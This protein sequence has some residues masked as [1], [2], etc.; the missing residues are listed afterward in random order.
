MEFIAEM[1]STFD[2]Y[3]LLP[4]EDKV[5]QSARQ[6][7]HLSIQMEV[8][9]NYWIHFVVLERSFDSYRVLGPS[10]EDLRLVFPYG[11]IVDLFKCD[12][13][14]KTVTDYPLE[15]IRKYVLV[16]LGDCSGIELR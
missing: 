16:T 2:G 12:Y 3:R 5:T 7:N 8:F 14:I 4:T 15:E 6:F 11:D 13:D 1:L 10:L 9:K